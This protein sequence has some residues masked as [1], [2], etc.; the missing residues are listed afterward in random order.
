MSKNSKLLDRL[1]ETRN[2]LVSTY[3]SYISLLVVCLLGMVSFIFSGY[4]L[5]LRHDIILFS[6]VLSSMFTILVSFSAIIRLIKEL[7]KLSKKKNKLK[8]KLYE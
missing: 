3:T 7:E 1:D 4:A 6:M 5:Y 2:E 8:V